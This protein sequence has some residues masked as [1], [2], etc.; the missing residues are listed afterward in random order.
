M[1]AYWLLPRLGQG[2][3]KVALF[4]F[5]DDYDPESYIERGNCLAIQKRY[6]EAVLMF[7]EA[8][9]R[10]RTDYK[11][12]LKIADMELNHLDDPAAAAQTLAESLNAQNWDVLE[13]LQL[14]TQLA[15]IQLYHLGNRPAA[16]SL[17]RFIEVRYGTHPIG[18]STLENGLRAM[19]PTTES[20][21]F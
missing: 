19:K 20:Q 9:D 6:E 21:A 10:E 13:H 16:E 17:Y 15:D 11:T 18:R 2:L 12:W 1:I 3:V 8:I 5:S 4:Q 7:K 14:I